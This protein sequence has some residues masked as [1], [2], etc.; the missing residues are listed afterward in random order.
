MFSGARSPGEGGETAVGGD[1]GAA[2]DDRG[3]GW[4]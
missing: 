4:G 2:V 1:D 3:N